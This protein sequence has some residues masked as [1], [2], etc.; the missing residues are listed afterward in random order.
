MKPNRF[1]ADRLE[2]FLQ[3][4]Q[5]ATLPQL[6]TALGTAVDGTVFRKL[7][8]LPYRT[9][10]SHRGAYYTLDTLAH[11]DDWRLWCGWSPRTPCGS[12]RSGNGFVG[13]TWGG[14]IFIAPWS[15]GGARSSGPL[16]RP[17]KVQRMIYRRRWCFSIVCSTSSSADS[18]PGWRVWSGATA[19]ING[20]H[21][22][23][24]WTRTPSRVDE[25]SCCAAK[26]SKSGC[27]EWA[28]DDRGPKKNA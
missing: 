14:A 9:S 23:L 19:A 2:V 17:S 27:V 8:T 28:A 21:G 25:W 13:G 22:S 3:H 1:T 18:I 10:Y 24:G 5:V 11:Y 16:G 26:C 4:N 12:W 7:S 6:K 20:W 15:A